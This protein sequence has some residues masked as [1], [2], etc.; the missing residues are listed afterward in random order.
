VNRL[1]EASG[2]IFD[3]D[4]N[5]FSRTEQVPRNALDERFRVVG[6][7]PSED[8]FSAPILYPNLEVKPRKVF[9]NKA[10]ARVCPVLSSAML[11]M[12]VIDDLVK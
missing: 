3:L 4:Q 7:D 10:L 11:Y 12:C 8:A 9:R 6:T 2:K 5:L 1:R